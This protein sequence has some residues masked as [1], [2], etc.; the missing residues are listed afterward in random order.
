M[1][2]KMM[3]ATTVVTLQAC[4]LISTTERTTAVAKINTATE[5]TRVK[6]VIRIMVTIGRASQKRMQ[7][8]S[9]MNSHFLLLKMARKLLKNFL[10][11]RW[12]LL[13][14]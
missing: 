10:N 13:E 14:S 4:K 8:S 9:S 12:K 5:T 3:V 11:R 2:T 1:K 6:E 7:V